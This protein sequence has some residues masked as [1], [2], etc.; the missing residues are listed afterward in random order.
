MGMLRVLSLRGDDCV[1]WDVTQA[2]AGIPEAVAAV[3]DAE[4]IFAESWARGA[5]ALKVA[6][7]QLPA[8]IDA[9]DPAAE[10]IVLV[11]RVMGG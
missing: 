2:T 10:Q 1:V 6:K 5:T 9:F 7:G 3:Q 8:R 11:S 4:R